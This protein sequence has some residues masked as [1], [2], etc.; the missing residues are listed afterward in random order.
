MRKTKDISALRNFPEPPDKGLNSFA[1]PLNIR[2]IR[3]IND[4]FLLV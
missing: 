4:F 2:E 3:R 1:N